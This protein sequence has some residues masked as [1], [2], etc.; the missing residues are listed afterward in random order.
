MKPVKW[1]KEDSIHCKKESYYVNIIASIITWSFICIVP[2]WLCCLTVTFKREFLI[3]KKSFELSI[4]GGK[5]MK[6][7][8]ETLVLVWMG[9]FVGEC[10]V[11]DHRTA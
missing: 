9:R 8:A 11:Y 7:I 4:D 3:H 10:A 6:A 1:W 5:V 2:I